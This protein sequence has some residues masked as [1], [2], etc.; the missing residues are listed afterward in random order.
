MPE[1]NLSGFAGRNYRLRLR[2]T[3]HPYYLTWL[4][5]LISAWERF[6]ILPTFQY[7]DYAK[8]DKLLAVVVSFAV[9]IFALIGWEKFL[10]T[11]F[12]LGLDFS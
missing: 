6:F 8:C 2:K 5:P 4:T 9:Y 1:G 11:S 7:R 10:A 12:G 3:A